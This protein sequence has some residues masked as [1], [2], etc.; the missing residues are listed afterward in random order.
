MCRETFGWGADCC[1]HCG[2]PW[3]EAWNLFDYD[4]RACWAKRQPISDDEQRQMIRVLEA[5]NVD[6]IH[7]SGSDRDSLQHAL[8]PVVSTPKH[9]RETRVN[10][11]RNAIVIR[12]RLE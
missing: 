11:R 9:T 5:Q 2:V 3:A 8:N 10:G 1:L 12:V 4:N 6:C 7:Y